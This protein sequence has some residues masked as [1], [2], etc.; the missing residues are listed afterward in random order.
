MMDATK[1]YDPTKPL[2]IDVPFK[3][4]SLL[5]FIWKENT[6]DYFLFYHANRVEVLD[7]K[8]IFE[9]NMKESKM[10]EMDILPTG[11]PGLITNK[12]VLSI[13]QRVCPDDFQV[14][15]I[16]I[17]SVPGKSKHKEFVNHDYFL[18]HIIKKI[19]AIDFEA[20]DFLLLDDSKPKVPNNILR[21]RKIR[22]K[23]NCMNSIHIARDEDYEPLE[24]ISQH[25]FHILLSENIFG[26]ECMPDYFSS[27]ERRNFPEL[28][29]DD[30]KVD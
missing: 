9:I 25:L 28:F 13:L 3:N 1:G 20:S 2:L 12:K 19:S 7:Y 27:Y 14:F 5:E 21:I 26:V 16:L 6:T 8:L 11:F 23:P 4:F 29:R 15:P 17:K 24:Y 30:G 18:I 10:L 22:F